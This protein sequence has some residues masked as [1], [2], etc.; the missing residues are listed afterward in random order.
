MANTLIISKNQLLILS[1][2]HII[3]ASSFD[4]K[5]DKLLTFARNK[6]T[7]INVINVHSVKEELYKYI[8]AQ[9][10]SI[11]CGQDTSFLTNKNQYI[12]PKKN[13]KLIWVSRYL[14]IFGKRSASEQQLEILAA[15]LTN[16]NTKRPNKGSVQAI[17][18]Y[19][20]AL[21]KKSLKSLLNKMNL[22]HFKHLT[23]T[24]KEI[25]L[26]I[27]NRLGIPCDGQTKH[28]AT[29]VTGTIR[30]KSKNVRRKKLIKLE[31]L[32]YIN[33]SKAKGIELSFNTNIKNVV[34]GSFI[35]QPS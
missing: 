20:G 9:G 34:I 6:Y 21:N 18:R 16:I 23:Q 14:P 29:Q 32:R 26:I 12:I 15:S 7:E 11:V 27:L 33:K 1:S 17:P 35:C 8:G 22:T 5:R 28:A 25:I 10:R 4:K 2:G 30:L 19:L 13:D 31:S 3:K 24:G